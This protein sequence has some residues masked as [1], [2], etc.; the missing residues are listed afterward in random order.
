MKDVLARRGAW[1]SIELLW[2]TKDA[3]AIN[4]PAGVATQAPSPYTSVETLLREQL[5]R[6]EAYLAFPHRLDRDVSGVLLVALT[7]R[8][9]NLL[10][11]QF[12][13][14]KTQK[15]YIAVVEGLFEPECSASPW[16]NWI[17]KVD[18]EARAELCQA[19]DRDAKEAV[20][21]VDESILDPTQART[22]LRLRPIT[23]R[24]HQLRL[25]CAVRSH[26]IVGDDL[27]GATMP[28]ND[29]SDL[30]NIASGEAKRRILL[31]AAQLAFHDPRTGKR[32]E[33]VAPCDF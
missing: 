19:S 20:T 27:Y 30:Q 10:S 12:A 14:R 5:D 33:V 4:K 28:T 8:A 25:Q 31:H 9:A 15:E 6:Q 29:E 11:G 21:H 13:S 3:I 2:Q 18:G 22:R 7:K 17:R 24:M 32:I 1:V 23:G 16:S 26:P